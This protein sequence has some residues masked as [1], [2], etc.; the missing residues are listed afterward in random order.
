M[1]RA[2]VVSMLESDWSRPNL[3]AT[4]RSM[5]TTSRR[6]Q[7]ERRT[8][9]RALLLEAA[10]ATLMEQGYTRTTTTEV[11][12]RAGLSQGALFKHFSTKSALVAAAAEQLF[13]E[14]IDEFSSAF[15]RTTDDEAS[16]VRALRRLWEVFCSPRLQAVYRLYVE[17]PV[18]SA[19]LAALVPVVRQH[20]K[21]LRA[22]A[23]A[24][25][26]E[27]E[28]TPAHTALFAA[29]LFAMQGVS[30]QRP[31]YVNPETER[32]IL[33]QFEVIGRSLIAVAQAGAPVHA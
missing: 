22:R 19:L 25:F 12:R 7:A 18:D 15:E 5:R 16:V 14:A 28:A 6:T 24:L 13:A 23:H 26:P 20:E 10:I 27:L 3:S 8:T 32:L 11:A 4:V 1:P 2:S 30:L 9:T 31:V 29:M 21:S 17:A 33:E